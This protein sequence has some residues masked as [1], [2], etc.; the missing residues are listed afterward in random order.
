MKQRQNT[1]NGTKFWN[2]KTRTPWGPSSTKAVASRSSPTVSPTGNRVFKYMSLWRTLLF[3]PPHCIW[4]WAEVHR[5][6]LPPVE[7][8]LNQIP[9]SQSLQLLFGSG[10][11]G[12]CE[13]VLQKHRPGMGDQGKKAS[14]QGVILN[15]I[16][17]KR[18]RDSERSSGTV[19]YWA[20]EAL[21]LYCSGGLCEQSWWGFRGCCE[22][23]A[24][25]FIDY[26]QDGQGKGW[27]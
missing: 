10:F 6:L 21:G 18:G 14:L 8:V 19:H 3:Q 4:H 27:R 12:V 16:W 7:I 5:G 17:N 2:F 24:V 26:R 23:L 13:G 15:K 20:E 25:C 22:K 11:L 1:G 9:P